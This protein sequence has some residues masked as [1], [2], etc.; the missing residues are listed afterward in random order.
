MAPVWELA[1]EDDLTPG[2]FDLKRACPLPLEDGQTPHMGMLSFS[3][4]CSVRNVTR[5]VGC[6]PTR[7][8]S[9][10]EPIGAMTSAAQRPRSQASEAFDMTIADSD[11][12][13]SPPVRTARRMIKDED[14]GPR[15]T[16]LGVR[17]RRKRA[18]WQG[19][20][21]GRF[22]ALAEDDTENHQQFTRSVWKGSGHR[23]GVS[24]QTKKTFEHYKTGGFR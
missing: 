20:S 8:D 17:S 5:R 11:L 22:A 14:D 12:S 24:N 10:D 9:D 6:N 15:S 23:S 1:L 4:G 18:S 19:F 7:L 2:D 13:E 3:F 16:M 21:G